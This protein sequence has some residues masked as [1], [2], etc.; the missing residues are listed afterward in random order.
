MKTFSILYQIVLR[1]V[2]NG[3]FGI[4]E[5]HHVRF[6]GSKEEENAENAEKNMYLQ[7]WLIQRVRKEKALTTVTRNIDH[8]DTTLFND[9]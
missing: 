6:K 7:S 8:N 3:A 2:S 9:F 1:S 4:P 5:Q